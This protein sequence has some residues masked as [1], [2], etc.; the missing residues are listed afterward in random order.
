[1]IKTA[2]RRIVLSAALVIGAAN[3]AAADA[4]YGCWSNGDERLEVTETSVTTTTGSSPEAQIDRHGATFIAPEGERD[5]GRRLV[6]RQLN[7]TTVARTVQLGAE[8]IAPPEREFW[9]PCGPAAIS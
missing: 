2:S 9:Q 8:Q 5:A 3:P 7:D 1:M 6:F 4:I